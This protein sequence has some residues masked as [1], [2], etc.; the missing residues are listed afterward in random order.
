METERRQYSEEFNKVTVAHSFA[1]DKTVKE[2]A[3]ALSIA[4][5]NLRCWRKEYSKRGELALSG[6]GGEKLTPQ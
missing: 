2:V 3:K 5:S 1:S 4:H 6:H